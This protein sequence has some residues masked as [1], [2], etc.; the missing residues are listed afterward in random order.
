MTTT[1]Y[2]RW[3]YTLF[4]MII[5]MNMMLTYGFVKVPIIHKKGTPITL[6]NKVRR[7]ERDVYSTYLLG[8]RRQQRKIFPKNTNIDT[9]SFLLNFTRQFSSN[10][11]NYTTI[12][13]TE[14]C[15]ESIIMGNIILD[16]SDIKYIHISTEKDNIKIKLD[17]NIKNS[18]TPPTNLIFN[19]LQNMDIIF[20]TVGLVGKIIN[21]N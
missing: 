6:M 13:N 19:G 3:T 4:I 21:I 7:K 9:L 18:T 10:Y 17:N 12:N 2:F 5:I 11:S 8:L 1:T 14:M 16:V 20:T 15:A